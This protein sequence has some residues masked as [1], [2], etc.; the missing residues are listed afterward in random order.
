DPLTELAEVAAGLAIGLIAE[1]AETMESPTSPYESDAWREIEHRLL[2]EVDLLSKG[3]KSVMG[4]HYRHGMQ[5][6]EIAALLQL[7][8]GR[9]SQLHRAAITRLRK[10]LNGSE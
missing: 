10:R 8:K 6:N 9:I 3:Q 4:H 2:A 1:R 5:F 7:S